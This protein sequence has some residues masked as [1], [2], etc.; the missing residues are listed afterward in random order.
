MF[1][2][3]DGKDPRALM[4]A[5]SGVKYV[6]LR[7]VE[8]PGGVW[9][10]LF[11]QLILGFRGW[12][13]ELILARK[14]MFY[15]SSHGGLIVEIVR[16]LAGQVVDYAAMEDK[17]IMFDQ[18]MLCEVRC[19][20]FLFPMKKEA[21]HVDVCR[22]FPSGSLLP[23]C[24][25]L[26][27]VWVVAEAWLWVLQIYQRCDLLLKQSCG[28]CKYINGHGTYVFSSLFIHPFKSVEKLLSVS[29]VSQECGEIVDGC[30]LFGHG[31]GL[32]SDVGDKGLSEVDEALDV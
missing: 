20:S 24:I 29:W 23:H 26:L 22:P 21:A 32:G 27:E 30:Y 10:G 17:F 1:A 9:I 6:G 8:V 28:C 4:V 7:E 14:G 12:F 13:V 11:S 19:I 5:E 31:G 16:I 2:S 3:Y 25:G 15:L 18:T